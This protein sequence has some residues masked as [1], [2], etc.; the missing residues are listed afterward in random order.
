MMRVNSWAPGFAPKAIA[1]SE[2]FKPKVAEPVMK[3]IDAMPAQWRLL[4]HEFDYIDVYRAWRQGK[5]P[6]F[7]RARAEANGGRFVL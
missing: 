7:V 1:G 4:V 5:S 3:A 2:E 6:Q